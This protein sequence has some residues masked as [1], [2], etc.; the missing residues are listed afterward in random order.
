MSRDRIKYC[1]MEPFEPQPESAVSQWS[2]GI[3]MF[4]AFVIPFVLLFASARYRLFADQARIQFDHF[5]NA[6][7]AKKL[8]AETPLPTPSHD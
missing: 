5:T 6:S 2:F 7:A 3:A 1:P 8:P 4:A